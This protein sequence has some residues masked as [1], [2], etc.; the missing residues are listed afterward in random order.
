M[1]LSGIRN[2]KMPSLLFFCNFANIEVDK[3][4]NKKRKLTCRS[5][6]GVNDNPLAQADLIG[7]S[8]ELSANFLFL[9]LCNP[10][11]DEKYNEVTNMCENIADCNKNALNA[12]DCMEEKTP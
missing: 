6:F 4:N 3:D 8:N 11:N 12:N 2:N 5:F 1:D 9:P 7:E 10:A